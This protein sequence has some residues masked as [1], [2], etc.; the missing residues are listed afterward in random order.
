MKASKA[1]HCIQ[2]GF[3]AVFVDSIRPYNRCYAN[4]NRI[5]PTIRDLI[6][7]EGY[8]FEVEEVDIDSLIS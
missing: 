2:R 7:R 6:K 5:K 1:Q 3:N 4:K 8:Q